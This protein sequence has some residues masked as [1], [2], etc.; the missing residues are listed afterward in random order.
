MFLA[1][2]V[3]HKDGYI[4]HTMWL[5]NTRISMGLLG[6]I[7][8]FTIYMFQRETS[9]SKTLVFKEFFNVGVNVTFE[10]LV[11]GWKDILKC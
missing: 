11:R 6:R 5:L 8:I 1:G 10:L 3:G 2:S 4:F 7:G 9:F